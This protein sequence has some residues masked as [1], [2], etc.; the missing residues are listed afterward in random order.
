MPYARAASSATSAP[1]PLSASKR[2]ASPLLDVKDLRVQYITP[3]GRVRAVDGISFSIEPGQTLG[4]VGESGSGKSTVAQAL[5]RVL[6]PPAVITGGQVHFRD[7]DVLSMTQSELERFRWRDISMV[8]QSAM[9]ALNPVMTIGEQIADVLRF[10]ADMSNADALDRAAELLD[11]V[12]IE[13]SR[14]KAYPHQLSGGM[15]QRAVIAI[16]LALKPSLLILDE[17]TTALDVVVQGEILD[18]I[19][20]LKAK[21]QFSVLFITHDFSL[22]VQM[23]D[24][25]AV[26]YAGQIVE[27]APSRQLFEKPLHPYTQGLISS[28]PSLDGPKQKLYGIPGSPPDMVKPPSGCRFHPRCAQFKPHHAEIMPELLDVEPGHG[29]AC[30][31]YTPEELEDAK[32]AGA[33]REP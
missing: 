8:F 29:V 32:L 25:I 18:Q 28:F 3:R 19:N 1:R 2:S 26:M 5:L 33:Q 14:L 31:L 23:A 12:N 20:D 10:H 4:L 21:L 13:R 9:N 11:I 27:I 6:R 24:T 15:R 22:L 17:P 7:Q 16:A 30:H